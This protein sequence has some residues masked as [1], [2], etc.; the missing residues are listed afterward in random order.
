MADRL[1]SP[2]GHRLGLLRSFLGGSPLWCAWQVTYRCR[3]RCR[4]CDYWRLRAPASEELSPADFARGAD[5]LGRLGTLMISLAGGEPLLR[6]DL[7]DVVAAVARRHITFF[8][9]SGFGLTEERARALW[10]AGLWGASVS[11]DYADAA[12][13]DAARGCPGAFD[14]A[15]RALTALSETRTAWHQ[16]VNLM[17]VLMHDNL[18]D[19]DALAEL[20]LRHRANLMVQPYGVRKTGSRAHLP[21]PP[22]S[23]RLLQLKRR[24]PNFLSNRWFLTRFDVHLN[25][26][27]PNCAAGVRFFNIDHRGR[28]SPC[29]ET[30]DRAVGSVLDDPAPVLV[31]RLR[32]SDVR[33]ACRDCWYNCRGETEALYS[34]RGFIEGLPTYVAGPLRSRWRR[35][36]GAG[37]A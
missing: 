36:V 29:V 12:R 20:A 11:I 21:E 19:L 27:V 28:V 23:A 4:F 7:E 13:H 17:A 10:Q 2:W 1:H 15:R 18:D 6:D 9:T 25:G 22:V 16:Q 37:S 30:M 31:R 8:T 14:G 32:R 3:M 35:R 26:G 33:A 34:I 5:N 24:W